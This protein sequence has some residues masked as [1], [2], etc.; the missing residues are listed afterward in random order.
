MPFVCTLR[1]FYK[2]LLS[3]R[4]IYLC[5]VYSA[6]LWT[7]KYKLLWWVATAVFSS[8]KMKI[9]AEALTPVLAVSAKIPC[10]ESLLLF[11]EMRRGNCH[12]KRNVGL[13]KNPNNTRWC[14]QTM[15]M[16][17][18]ARC[19]DLW[20]GSYRHLDGPKTTMLIRSVS[21]YLANHTAQYPTRYENSPRCLSVYHHD[22]KYS[23][24]AHSY[25]VC[26]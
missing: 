22:V 11:R 10:V 7:R 21:K 16:T 20:T 15:V 9:L 23:P 3:S 2:W 19:D 5:K 6:C 1:S 8:I 25:A 4:I 26:R 24:F 14:S 13:P 17:C 12:L 18:L